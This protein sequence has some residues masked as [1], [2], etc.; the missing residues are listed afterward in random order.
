MKDSAKDRR[1]LKTK[2][3]IHAAFIKLLDKKGYNKISIKDIADEAN[4]DR[5]TIYYYYNGVY[6]IR[7]EIE[8]EFIAL[9]EDAATELDFHKYEENP[10][11]IFELLTEIINNNI[12][13]YS[14]FLK[15]DA[16]SHIIRKMIA[17]FSEK[18]KNG[19]EKS[20]LAS[21][22]SEKLEVISNF[23]TSGMV[24]AYQNWFNSGCKQ[25]LEEVSKELGEIILYG[26]KS[27]EQK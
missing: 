1:I 17:L 24:A 5:K 9:V 11:H 22:D 14:S 26:I 13:A 16:H 15:W 2:K 3:A 18:V 27:L 25:S 23:I 12:E 6:E 21:Q 19:F 10:Q 8:N 7:D 4:C 20:A